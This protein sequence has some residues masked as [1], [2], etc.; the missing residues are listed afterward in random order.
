MGNL[1]EVFGTEFSRAF[2][3]FETTLA[4]PK[5]LN[6]NVDQSMK[7]VDIIGL[8]DVSQRAELLIGEAKSSRRYDKQSIEE[9]YEHL[10]NLHVEEA[11]R[12]LRFMKE[13]L[14]LRGERQLVENV[15]HHMARR[16]PRRYL[17]L[18][19]TQSAPED[20]FDVI[21]AQFKKARIPQLL[22]VHIQISNLKGRPA[23][24]KRDEDEN[25][26]SKL[27]AS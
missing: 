6:P 18:S 7:G 14:S 22:A 17:I 21:T 1:G 13:V 2:L 3:R 27:F 26:L 20:P 15:D 23:G 5:R 10:I 12:I 24:S 16:V 8:R 25:W 11:S 9:A 4:F 19:I